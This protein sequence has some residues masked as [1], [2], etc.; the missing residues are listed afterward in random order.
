[1]D[2]LTYLEDTEN[3]IPIFVITFAAAREDEVAP[4]TEYTFGRIFDGREDLV[5]AFRSAKGYN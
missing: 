1:M 5:A 2:L 4:M 3:D